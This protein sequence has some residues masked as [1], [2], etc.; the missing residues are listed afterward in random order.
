MPLGGGERKKEREKVVYLLHTC[1][2][3]LHAVMV[4]NLANNSSDLVTI[5]I[6]PALDTLLETRIAFSQNQ[7]NCLLS[8]SSNFEVT[9]GER[10]K[11]G[12]CFWEKH[13]GKIKSK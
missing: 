9:L 13:F 2:L 6:V 7:K 5:N 3:G 4:Y 11:K 1:V 12:N 8:Y 10:G